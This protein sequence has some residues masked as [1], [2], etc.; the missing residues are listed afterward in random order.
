[1]AYHEDNLRIRPN[2][3]HVLHHLHV[4]LVVIVAGDIIHCSSIVRTQIDDHQVSHTM[5]GEIPRFRFVAEGCI[6]AVAHI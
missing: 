4:A 3:M 6:R 1:M 5:S 2:A